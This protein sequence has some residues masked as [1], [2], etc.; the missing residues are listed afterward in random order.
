MKEVTPTELKQMLDNKEDIQLIDVR[1]LYEY[2]AAHIQ[3][4]LIPLN[5]IPQNLDKISKNKKVIMICRSGNRSG[6]A[7]RFMEGNGF[8]NL[9]NLKGGMLAW[10]KEIDASMNVS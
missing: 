3:A 10:K 5:T 8:E 2:Q 6:N 1:E 7:I 4:E 9:Y